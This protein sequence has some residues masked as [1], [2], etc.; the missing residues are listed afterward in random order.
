[1]RRLRYRGGGGVASSS[2]CLGRE[3]RVGEIAFRRFG[4]RR[5]GCLLVLLRLL[6]L[7]FPL[8]ERDGVETFG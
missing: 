8:K 7:P 3:V 2:G 1:M 4:V 6:V 5:R